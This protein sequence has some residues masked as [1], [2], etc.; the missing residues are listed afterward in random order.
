MK[1]KTSQ[2]LKKLFIRLLFATILRVKKTSL[3]FILFI[4]SWQ[5][6]GRENKSDW[7]KFFEDL[8]NRELKHI[9]IIVSDDLHGLIDAIKISYLY[10]HHQL[11]LVYL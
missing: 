9:L 6:L 10:I 1:S 5:R 7:N 3:V 4:Y 8:I 2:K 11:C